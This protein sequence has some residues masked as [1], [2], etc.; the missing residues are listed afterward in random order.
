MT[1]AQSFV[2]EI[3]RFLVRTGMA[4]STF[5]RRVANDHK[6][7][8]RLRAGGTVRL[9]TADHIRQFMADFEEERPNGR[10]AA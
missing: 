6:L 1:Q 5:G 8:K 10:R 7:V 9:P 2:A 4:P 3:E